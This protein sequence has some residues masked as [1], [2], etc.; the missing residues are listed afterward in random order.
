MTVALNYY[1]TVSLDEFYKEYKAI[2]IKKDKIT[3]KKLNTNIALEKRNNENIAFSKE[4][5]ISRKKDLT[6]AQKIAYLKMEKN[7]ISQN[8]NGHQ[9]KSSESTNIK[10]NVKKLRK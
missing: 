5:V 10:T 8:S 1:I 7:R 2:L 3:K 6:N 9:K 4:K